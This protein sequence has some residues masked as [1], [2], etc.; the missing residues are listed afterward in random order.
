MR[1]KLQAKYRDSL[2]HLPDANGKPVKPDGKRPHTTPKKRAR[3]WIRTT[4]A[5]PTAVRRKTDESHRRQ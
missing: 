4:T 1:L 3:R 2:R 5:Y